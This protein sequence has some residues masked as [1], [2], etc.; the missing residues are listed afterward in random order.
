[1]EKAA[2]LIPII[3]V[4]LAAA[5]FPLVS[6]LTAS[7]KTTDL[8]VVSFVVKDSGFEVTLHNTGDQRSIIT[9]VI[10]TVRRFEDLPFCNSQG[11]VPL[12]GN[13]GVVI[14]INPAPGEVI[15]VPISQQAGPDQA[16][17]FEV[18]LQISRNAE[19]EDAFLYQFDIAFLHD[20]DA[21]A[22]E[23][24]KIV[25]L[26]AGNALFWTKSYAA[27]G[28]AAFSWLGSLA[29]KVINCMKSNT[30]RV[31]ESLSWQGQHSQLLYQLA[32]TLPGS[33]GSNTDLVRP[34][35]PSANPGPTNI[36]P[37]SFL[38]HLRASCRR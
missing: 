14:P 13:Y 1:M 18:R 12:T 10:L 31:R 32:Q 29:S 5:L 7:K 3:V 8:H 9:Q 6:H 17:R 36:P 15:R 30:T 34:S 26:S 35:Q 21:Q 11:A 38:G 22:L 28:S 25:L 37:Y 20:T 4:F 33:R 19:T 23:A 27:E 2:I 24:G 16:D